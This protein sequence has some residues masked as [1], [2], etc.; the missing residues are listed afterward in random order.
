VIV[1]QGLLGGVFWSVSSLPDPLH[2]VARVL[3]LTYAIDGL[4]AVLIRASDLSSSD[5]Q[6]D[7]AFL[8]GTAILFVLLG[9]ATIRREIA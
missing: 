5:L 9:G 6:L 8:A 4:R 1:P 2:G 7:L 3:P